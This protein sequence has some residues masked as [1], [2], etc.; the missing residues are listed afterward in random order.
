MI[1]RRRRRR[2]GVVELA[3]PRLVS[4]SCDVT[5]TRRAAEISTLD[6][7]MNRVR[8]W[9]TPKKSTETDQKE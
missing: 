6:K 2:G 8:G 5:K 1:R 9:Q 4:Q 3:M 7:T